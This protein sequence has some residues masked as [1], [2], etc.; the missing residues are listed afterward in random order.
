MCDVYSIAPVLFCDGKIHALE[1][2]IVGVY[3]TRRQA[4]PRAKGYT[5]SVAALWLFALYA[6]CC[7]G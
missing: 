5:S 3:V 7:K 6:S 4:R 2:S 1:F